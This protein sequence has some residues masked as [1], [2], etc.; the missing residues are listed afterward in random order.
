[1][2]QQLTQPEVTVA[3]RVALYDQQGVF[4]FAGVGEADCL[5]YADLFALAAGSFTLVS[6]EPGPCAL[7]SRAGCSS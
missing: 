3:P 6:L 5:A 1:M 4:R 7:V 2:S